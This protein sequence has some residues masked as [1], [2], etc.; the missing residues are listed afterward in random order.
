MMKKIFIL[1]CCLVIFSGC[2]NKVKNNLKKI[3]QNKPLNKLEH[4][5]SYKINI[6]DNPEVP[7]W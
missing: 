6:K 3:D 1:I 4:I 2:S 7:S 5:K